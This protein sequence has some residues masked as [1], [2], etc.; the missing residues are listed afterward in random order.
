MNADSSTITLRT[1]RSSTTRLAIRT[2]LTTGLYLF[3]GLLL[4]LSTGIGVSN[5]PMHVSKQIGTVLTTIPVL[6]LLFVAGTLW[7]R[8]LGRLFGLN[9]TRRMVRAGAL[10]FAPSIILAGIARSLLEV[11]IIER[12]NGP[13]LPVHILFTLLFVPAAF[14]VAGIGSLAIGFAIRGGMYAI[15][16]ALGGD[17]SGAL[18][19][20][21]VNLGMDALGWRVG[22]PG[23]A[24]RATM[25]RVMMLGNLAAAL[26]G[27][28]AIGA[29]HNSGGK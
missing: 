20:L 3:G 18:A 27:G 6:G 22:A 24:E 8:A 15:K 1:L 11:F 7:G 17:L 28:A 10:S 12:S 16:L 21:V 13:D 26:A 25:I 2:G 23:A 19:F 14:F 5:L 9:E 29:L 4:G